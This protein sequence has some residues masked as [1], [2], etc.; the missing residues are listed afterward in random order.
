MKTKLFL[1]TL[2]LMVCSCVKDEP[3]EPTPIPPVVVEGFGCVEVHVSKTNIE[4]VKF[5][6]GY[7]VYFFDNIRMYWGTAGDYY[8]K[9]CDIKNLE[10]D[11]YIRY[12]DNST[13]SKGKITV[14]KDQ[15]VILWGI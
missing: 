1:L 4:S 8:V 3:V 12:K 14:V 2:I 9:F 15:T 13:M 10:F 6:K 11:Y 5:E 7:D